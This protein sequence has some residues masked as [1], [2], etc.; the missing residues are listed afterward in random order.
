MIDAGQRDEG[1]ALRAKSSVVRWSG[2]EWGGVGW[3]GW[4]EGGWMGGWV[5]NAGCG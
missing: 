2:V 4:M 3:G 5:R 1:P